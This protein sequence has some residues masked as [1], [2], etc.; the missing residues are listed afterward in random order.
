MSG[1]PTRILHP[2][3]FS[4]EGFGAFAHALRL[5]LATR[6]RLYLLHVETDHDRQTMEAAGS[7]WTKFPSIHEILVQWGFLGPNDPP[8]AIATKLGIQVSKE[9]LLDAHARR[10]ISD[11]AIEHRCDMLV[12]GTHARHGL[13]RWLIPSIS[14][15]AS[16]LARLPCLFVP[17]PG[18][19]F[20]DVRTG[21]TDLDCLLIP[22]DARFGAVSAMRRIE[23]IVRPLAHRTRIELL[24]VGDTRPK[25]LDDD[26]TESDLPVD[27][28]RGP[29]V[30]TILQ[31]AGEIGA[32]L[33]AMPTAGRHG[34][35]DGLRGST[36][37]Q[38]LHRAPCPV[39]AIPER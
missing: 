5:A 31:T 19:G 11:Y 36:T 6:A 10:S 32:R 2:T 15:D 22:I 23:A 1:V 27:V 7:E 16:Q 13:R 8:A 12:M 37:E 9:L 25:V 4:E 34:F 38:V 28:R 26:G 39:L 24:H 30:A 20:V 21:A 29:V 35:L 33:I 17:Q 14:E 18:R 3:D